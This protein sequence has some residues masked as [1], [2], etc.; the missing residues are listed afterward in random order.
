MKTNFSQRLVM[1]LH[2]AN[3]LVDV[4]TDT[5]DVVQSRL[6]A[7]AEMVAAE[8]TATD[9]GEWL[10]ARAAK[11]GISGLVLTIIESQYSRR[12]TWSASLMEGIGDTSISGYGKSTEEAIA[13]LRAKI[14]SPAEIAD[15]KRAEI[16]R[17]TAELAAMEG[18]KS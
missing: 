8:L 12:F 1:A 6:D 10:R 3:Y 7:I 17:L 18:G 5:I 9:V 14:K 11:E 15:A 4:N 2:H 13:A 16:A